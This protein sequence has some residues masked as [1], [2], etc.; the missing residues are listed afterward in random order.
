MNKFKNAQEAFEFYYDEILNNGIDFDGTKALFNIGFEILNPMDNKINTPWRKWKNSYAIREWEWYLSGDK[1]A[2]EIS[3]F[4]STWKNVMDENGD[5]QSNYGWQWNRNNQL[6]KIIEKLKFKPNTRHAVLS[7]Y[8]GKEIENYKYDTPCTLNIGFQIIN[9]K[10]NMT[11]TMRSNDL[12]YGFCN[13]Q[14][15]FSKLQ[16]MVANEL[17]LEVG[18]YFH[19]VFNLHI[20][21]KHFKLK[22][23]YDI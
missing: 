12:I 7:I 3:K 17:N 9:N 22:E 23:K 20:Y 19:F 15:C 1:S 18:T 2:L 21:Y 8:D 4:A 13:D 16:E 11:V 6:N 10:L 5:V 14:Y